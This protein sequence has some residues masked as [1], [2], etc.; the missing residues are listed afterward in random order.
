MNSFFEQLF[1]WAWNKAVS[2]PSHPTNP[3]SVN[4][5]ELI[6]DGRITQNRVVIP[7]LKRAEHMALLGRT[8]TGKSSLLR[9]MASQDI[10]NNRGFL[11]FDLHG[12]ATPILLQLLAQREQISREDLSAK[13][14][15]I[16]PGDPEYSV[17]LNILES[18]GAQHSFV[19]IAEFAGLLKQRWHLDSFGAR[20]EE[21]LRNGL[22]LLAENN[23]TL[24]ELSPLLT[25]ETFRA[26]CLRSAGSGEARDYFAARYNQ[27]SEGQQN[28]FRDAVLN[29]VSAFTADPHFRHILGQSRSTFSL[30]DAIDRGFF[31]ILNLNKGTL[32]EHA[33]TLGSMLLTKV[34]NA[35][36]ARRRRQLFTLYCDEIQNLVAFDSSLDTLL[37]E[38]RKFAIGVVSANQFLD[39]YPTQMRSAIMAIGTHILFQLSSQDADKMSAALDGG[40]HL[41]E[42]LKNL[43][44]RNLVVKSGHEHYRLAVVPD[45]SAPRADFQDLYRRCRIRWA[46]RRTDVER[47]IRSRIRIDHGQQTREALDGWV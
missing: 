30:I 29:K 23:L 11:F 2:K 46:R 31:I 10:T 1:S 12:D 34:K 39:Q 44:P 45:F 5:G 26:R 16:E 15:L 24:L 14:I 7:Q 9:Y 4:L 3:H 47:E 19:Q 20:T 27:A 21:L 32:G 43:P 17:G 42:I 13:V 6:H 37:S 36:F 8:G 18:A 41:S 38:A 25:D 35:L 28:Q 22:L 40:K 33:A